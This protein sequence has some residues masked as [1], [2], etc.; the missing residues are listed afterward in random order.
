MSEQI[1]A[2]TGLIIYAVLLIRTEPAINRMRKDTTP[3]KVRLTFALLAA[4]SAGGI[5]SII[6]GR[7]PSLI[8]LCISGGITALLLCERRVRLITRFN[9]QKKG[10]RHAQR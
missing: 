6:S 7:V 3:F 1:L 8:D 2:L 10:L 5:L 9:S 4:G